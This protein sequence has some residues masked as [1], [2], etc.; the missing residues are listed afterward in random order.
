MP[1]RRLGVLLPLYA[2]FAGLQAL[3]AHSTMRALQNGATERNPLLGDV[4]GQPAALFALKAGVTASTISPDREAA[5]ETPWWAAIALMTALDSFY[6]MV[7]VHNYRAT[8]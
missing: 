8:R 5:P 6:A 2:S 3:D 4:A 1:S 7:V